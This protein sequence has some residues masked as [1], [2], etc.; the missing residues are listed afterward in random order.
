MKK[1]RFKVRVFPS[2]I[3]LTTQYEFFIICLNISGQQMARIY[4]KCH[5]ENV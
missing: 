4:D 1:D 2:K 3:H 5:I